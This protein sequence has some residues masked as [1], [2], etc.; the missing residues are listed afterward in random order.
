MCE[1][2][3]SSM[4]VQGLEFPETVDE[5]SPRQIA[6]RTVKAPLVMYQLATTNSTDPSKIVESVCYTAQHLGARRMICKQ[7]PLRNYTPNPN[8][9]P[10]P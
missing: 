4:E 3:S 2:I 1:E 7:G 5:P 10:V 8:L 9:N 6:M